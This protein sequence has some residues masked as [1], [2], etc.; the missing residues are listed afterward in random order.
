[1]VSIHALTSGRELNQGPL[2]AT[3]VPFFM[4]L[5]GSANKPLPG[6]CFAGEVFT[7]ALHFPSAALFLRLIT[8]HCR[9]LELPPHG[10][11]PESCVLVAQTRRALSAVLS[12]TFKKIPRGAVVA[13]SMLISIAPIRPGSVP[14]GPRVSTEQG[15]SLRRLLL[16]MKVFVTC[17]HH[18]E[19]MMIHV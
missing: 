13:Q 17:S 14:L 8:S 2:A 16:H 10:S 18:G 1:M 12:G 19:N 7:T 4:P 11:V 5:K 9:V 3:R 15:P 6:F